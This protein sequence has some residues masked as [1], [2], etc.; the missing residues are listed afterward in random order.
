MKK[1]TSILGGLAFT[2]A[3]FGLLVSCSPEPTNVD[4]VQASAS[5]PWRVIFT[6]EDLEPNNGTNNVK[7]SL[8]QDYTGDTLA[9]YQVGSGGVQVINM[10]Q[11]RLINKGLLAQ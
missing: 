11:Q 6:A 7:Y 3:S 1:F 8:I 2:A 10:S 9:I 5:K 4:L